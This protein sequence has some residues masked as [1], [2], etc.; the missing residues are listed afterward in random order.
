V[1][2]KHFK[3]FFW[4]FDH[5][6]IVDQVFIARIFSHFVTE[7]D[8]LLLDSPCTL[9]EI[10]EVLKSFAK[11]K[12]LGPDG[13][14]VKVFLQF[15]DLV[16]SKQLEVVEDTRS[17]GKVIISVNSNFLT[18]IPKVNNPFTFGD[19]KPIALRNLCYKL[20]TKIIANRIKP[21][22]LRTL[23]GKQLGFLKGRQ[24]MD[25]IGSTKEFFHSIKMKK[26]KA[27]ILKLD[28]IKYFNCIDW[29]FLWWILIQ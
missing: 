2:T 11:D 18:L 26:S 6:S 9:Q 4:A 8:T 14:T 22:L 21:I 15:F 19:Y 1:A 28:L 25:S 20:I 23:S 7:E 27:I 13:W 12:I 10:W 29:D 3:Y 17:C 16:G 24:I 5:T